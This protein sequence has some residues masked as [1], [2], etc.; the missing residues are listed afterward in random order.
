MNFFKNMIHK[1]QLSSL[2]R[3]GRISYSLA[4]EDLILARYFEEK[5]TGFYVE[6]GA[7]H[8]VRFS[9]SYLFYK[10]G[11]RG[12]NIDARP[13][14]MK[15]FNKIRPHDNN[16]E[17]AVSDRKEEL[18][19]YMFNEPALNGF[20]KDIS[21]ERETQKFKIIDKK[22]IKTNLLADILDEHCQQ[23]HLDFM[24][25]DVEGFDL[26]V[27]KSNNWERFRPEII[28]VEDLDF[29]S[30]SLNKSAT[31]EFLITK[32]YRFFGKTLHTILYRLDT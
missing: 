22:Q 24:S 10:K 6:V 21:T 14:S 4:G 20:N 19:Y 2:N 13:G 29:D 26:Q 18:T 28:L 9:N 7:Y 31:A 23:K 1:F 12:I 3:F 27:L 16:I 25:V 17:A 30:L 8:P 15:L 5:K 32:G 11:W